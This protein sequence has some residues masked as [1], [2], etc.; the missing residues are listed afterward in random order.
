[1]L[2]LNKLS[3]IQLPLNWPSWVRTFLLFYKAF[4]LLWRMHLWYIDYLCSSI[5]GSW[6]QAPL[7][8]GLQMG[9]ITNL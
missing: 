7:A 3:F 6:L 4:H 5:T 8:T 2:L 9:G 1:L